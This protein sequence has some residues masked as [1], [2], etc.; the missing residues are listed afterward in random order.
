MA[1]AWHN[2][3][4][5]DDTTAAFNLN[6]RITRYGDGFFETIL[7]VKFQPA[8]LVYHFERLLASAEILELILPPDF[9]IATFGAAIM[10]VCER[11]S[12]AYQRI[13][14]VVYRNG[15]GTYLPNSNYAGIFI[16][17][18]TI[19][20]EPTCI[21]LN[22]VGI[23][24]T[25]T[26][27]MNI[28]SALKTSNALLYVL[29]A[30]FAKENG[31]DDV[32]LLNSE[33]RICE[34][35]SSNLFVMKDGKIYTPSIAEGCVEGVLRKVFLTQFEVEERAITPSFLYAADSVFLTNTIQGVRA[36]KS[37][38]NITY[39]IEPV[40]QIHERYMALLSAH[41]GKLF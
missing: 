27:P 9:S 21:Q 18:Q 2:G 34:A 3:L 28:L 1:T 22:N 5:V 32:L 13:R 25:I 35:T 37:I 19:A 16:T 39:S 23:Y 29:A 12:S 31:L 26:K 36:I 40:L 14:V 30:N 15:G 20:F 6:H 17:S 41:V 10:Q 8:W 38:N 7:A 33:G 24:E 4:L 11:N